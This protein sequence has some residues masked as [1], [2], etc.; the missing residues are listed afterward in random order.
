MRRVLLPLLAAFVLWRALPATAANELQQGITMTVYPEVILASG[1]WQTPPESAPCFSGVV[2]NIDFDWGGMPAAEG[3]PADFFMVHF[4]GW[5]TVPETGDWE[6]LNWSD[7]G[8]RM[9][10]GGIVALDDW[11]FHGCGGHWS[12]PNEGFTPMVAGVSQPLDVWVFE[13]SGG[14]C[15]RLWYGSPTGYGVVPTEWLSTEA[16]PLPE[17]SPDPTPLPSVQPSEEVP[18]YEPTPPPEPSPIDSPQ[19]S[20][21][22]DFSPEPSPTPSPVEPPPSPA[23]P[24]PTPTP[25]PTPET[26]TPSPSVAQT[27]T[28]EPSPEVSPEVSPEPTPEPTPE[29]VT[30]DPG[31]AAEEVAAAIGE[32][33]A[34][35]S[36][37]V[38]QAAAFVA[39]LGHD[40]TPAEKEK[41]AATIVPAVIVTQVAQAAAAAAAAASSIGGSRKAKP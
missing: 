16:Q 20:P 39:N 27:P 9:T 22:A 24:S 21:S 29:P 13:W 26:P 28:P 37:A 17:P 23:T 38:T 34:A 30:F 1:P 2:P 40:L 10:I 35:V 33:A 36:E 8:W 15:A 19:P 6:W 5:L 7:D 32:A 41:A 11:N 25:T 18:T 3:C 12:G 14:A 4:T 31:A